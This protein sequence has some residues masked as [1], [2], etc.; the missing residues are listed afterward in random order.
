MK[1]VLWIAVAALGFAAPAAAQSFDFSTTYVYERWSENGLKIN[2]NGYAVSGAGYLN[3]WF[4]I[5]GEF[6]QSWGD[7]EV[8]PGADTDARH[9]WALGGVVA[10]PYRTDAGNFYLHALGGGGRFTVGTGSL[11][12]RDSGGIFKI[13]AGFDWYP[14]GNPHFGVR[15][16]EANYKSGWFFGERQNVF[17][18]QAGVVFSSGRP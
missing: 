6:G 4:G 17:Q 10:S 15:V 3:Q 13:G 11:Q 9:Y 5:K 12:A 8:S 7:V 16:F 1:R 14:G 18:L 2:M